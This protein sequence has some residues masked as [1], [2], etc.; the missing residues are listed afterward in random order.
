MLDRD[1]IPATAGLSDIIV[2]EYGSRIG[3]GICGSLL[4]QL[5]AT[6]VLVE[7]SQATAS[8]SHK[9]RSRPHF[10]IDKLSIVLRDDVEDRARLATLLERADVIVTSS[11]VDR[12]ENIQ[13]ESA[14]T[15]LCDITAFGA[16]GPLAGQP[17]SELQV[18][19]LSGIMDTTGLADGSPTPIAVP[20]AE[21][22]AGVHGAASVLA[23][24][25]ERD[26][27]GLGQ[28]VDSALFDSAFASMATFLPAVLM[29]SE[30]QAKRL[31]NRHAM[32][33][34]WNVHQAKD[35]WLLLC[36]NS[37][38]Q[39]QRLCELMARPEL[40]ADPGL[41][42]MADRVARVDEIDRAIGCWISAHTVESAL[43]LL[44][45]ASISSG[46]I[47]KIE[48]FPR[49]RNIE[50][51][52]LIAEVHDARSGKDYFVARPPLRVG[53]SVDN[54]P[55]LPVPDQDRDSVLRITQRDGQAS[56]PRREP[57]NLP[58]AGLQVLE[59]GHYTTVPLCAR[60]LANLGAEVIKIEP[61]E[62][63]PVR[64]FPPLKEGVGI[65][66]QYTNS[67]KKS[68]TLDLNR[69][70]DCETLKRLIETSDVLIE[71]LRP[72]ALAR[73]GFSW[74]TMRDINPT[75][76]YCSVSGF[77]VDSIYAQRPAV[78][79]VIQAMSGM[80]DVIIAG[81]V[82]V[83]SGISTA[84]L[85]GAQFALVAILGALRLR[86]TAGSGRH[87]DLSMQDI[88]AWACQTA[89]NEGPRPAVAVLECR[90]GFALVEQSE[91]DVRTRLRDLTLQPEALDRDQL[92]AA[93]GRINLAATPI[94]AA[95]E[96]PHHPQ[97]A[98]RALWFEVEKD[99]TRWP[100]L[101][102]PLRL[103]ATPPRVTAPMG[104]AGCDGATIM[105]A[106][107]ASRRSSSADLARV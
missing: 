36:A 45:R 17:G 97:T 55:R 70:D 42:R 83:K 12:F 52:K 92:I 1:L 68:L 91:T 65:Y 88:A 25:H 82:P 78:D 8:I 18:Q 74:T 105:Q 48:R 93:L 43:G 101:K 84:D 51:R 102:S 31:G 98:A 73:R 40:A 106:L 75:L 85:L 2:V 37:N 58:L 54:A 67:D 94:L 104:S 49:E 76:I 100:M 16:D 56:R 24:L 3:V 23:A 57:R 89:W 96:L 66:F 47:V 11:D 21:I 26:R 79:S 14:R 53:L 38:A 86:G 103:S 6:V 34:P 39:W 90:D 27:S 81:G 7:P 13:A 5:G 63:E 44:E 33:A 10:A 30:G 9:W 71:N 28:T 61:P 99:G 50:H 62:G 77:G 20:I 19:A 22:M 41:A 35:G 64:T 87:I 60:H 95:R 15:I 32:I 72:G 46:P 29:G 4:A 69:A 59:I 107:N 80:M